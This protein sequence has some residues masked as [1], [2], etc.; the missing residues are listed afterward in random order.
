VSTRQPRFSSVIKHLA[1]LRIEL[2]E[3][4]SG[5]KSMSGRYTVGKRRRRSAEETRQA[6]LAL[7]RPRGLAGERG[8]WAVRQGDHVAAPPMG[9][10]AMSVGTSAGAPLPRSQAGTETP[11]G[12]PFRR[13]GRDRTVHC[14]SP[15]SN[16]VADRQPAR[17]CFRCK[18]VGFDKCHV[19]YD[20]W[21]RRGGRD[22]GSA[23]TRS[24]ERLHPRNRA[25]AL[26]RPR[27]AVGDGCDLHRPVGRHRR[28]EGRSH[29]ASA[30]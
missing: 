18:L 10:A 19:L 14:D 11:F 23:A 29:L 12:S 25:T 6:C 17:G 8:V 28:C 30:S 1:R 16:G 22:A 21:L 5:R 24:A 15:G 4:E 9:T 13:I 20:N 3:I 2:D 26:L 7:S 27:S